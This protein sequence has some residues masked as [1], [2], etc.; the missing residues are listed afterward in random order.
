MKI[1]ELH[2][3]IFFL[4]FIYLYLQ[5][6]A[7]KKMCSLQVELEVLLR[8]RLFFLPS[9]GYI[10]TRLV[11]K[12]YSGKKQSSRKILNFHLVVKTS[13]TFFFSDLFLSCKSSWLFR[14]NLMKK[15]RNKGKNVEILQIKIKIHKKLKLDLVI[16]KAEIYVLNIFLW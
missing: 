16:P 10:N 9:L 8:T 1:N 7:G 11:D 14:R 13:I 6:I 5:N 12:T 4:Y 2:A 15:R 3:R